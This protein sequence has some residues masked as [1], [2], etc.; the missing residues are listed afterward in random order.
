[1]NDEREIMYEEVNFEYF[2]VFNWP[3]DT[4]E[5]NVN[6]QLSGFLLLF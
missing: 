4:E 6:F 5:N 1:M 3:E 2:K